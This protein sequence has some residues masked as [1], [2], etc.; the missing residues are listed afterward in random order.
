MARNGPKCALECCLTHIERPAGADR[1][2]RGSE[3]PPFGGLSAA[4]GPLG[5]AARPFPPRA[6]AE[7]DESRQTC[8]TPYPNYK[9]MK[10]LAFLSGQGF[11]KSNDFD[12]CLEIL[13]TIV[14]KISK[15]FRM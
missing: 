7:C 10:A 3:R 14:E 12:I 4:H 1:D 2:T 5:G 6:G 11:K 13:S 9:K 15:N 8:V